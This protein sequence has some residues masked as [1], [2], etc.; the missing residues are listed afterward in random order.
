MSKVLIFAGTTEGRELSLLLSD[1][2]IPCE[3]CVATEYG[4]AV[5]P[6]IPGVEVH[7][8]RMDTEQMKALM[9][10]KGCQVIV[11]ATHPFAVQVSENIRQAAAFCDIPGL[12]LKRETGEKNGVGEGKEPEDKEP[13]GQESGESAATGSRGAVHYMPDAKACADY[14]GQTGGNILLT[15]GSKELSVYCTRKNSRNGCM[16]E[17]CQEWRV[18]ASVRRTD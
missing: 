6:R 18:L 4:E 14:L 13:E 2:Q 9:K 10:Q 11:D 7:R 8:G 16:C 1:N 17:Y 3:V 12:R 5:M 15:T